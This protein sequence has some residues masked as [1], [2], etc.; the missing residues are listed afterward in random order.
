LGSCFVKGKLAD[1]VKM[2]N[3]FKT[4]LFKAPLFPKI[5]QNM[6]FLGVF[7]IKTVEFPIITP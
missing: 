7:T 4:G 6:G 1:F 2:R 3:Q 5:P